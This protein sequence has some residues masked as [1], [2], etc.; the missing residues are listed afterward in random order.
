MVRSPEVSQ[1]ETL[2]M[3]R[4]VRKLL[5]SDFEKS[6]SRTSRCIARFLQAFH[7]DVLQLPPR[8]RLAAHAGDRSATS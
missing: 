3:Q 8:L 4:L 6:T 2:L 7:A 1:H 5:A